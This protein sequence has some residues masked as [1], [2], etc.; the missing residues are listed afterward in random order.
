MTRKCKCKC[1]KCGQ[2][3]ILFTWETTCG[4]GQHT[5]IKMFAI[6]DLKGNLIRQ[7]NAV[8]HC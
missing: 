2:P 6:E 1:K 8:S 3:Y 5:F 4:L 7:G